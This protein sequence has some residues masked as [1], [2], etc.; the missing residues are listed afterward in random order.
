MAERLRVQRVGRREFSGATL[1]RLRRAVQRCAFVAVDTELGGL[2]CLDQ[3]VSCSDVVSSLRVHVSLSRSRCVHVRVALLSNAVRVVFGVTKGL[4]AAAFAVDRM[5][6][7]VMDAVETRYA[8]LRASAQQFPIVEFGLSVFTWDQRARAFRVETFAFPIFPV[9]HEPTDQHAQAQYTSEA[10]ASAAAPAAPAPA[11]LQQLPDRRFLLQAKC[12][13]YIRAHGFDLNRW[14]DEGIGYLSHREQRELGREL[15]SVPPGSVKY[16]HMDTRPGRGPGA[17]SLVSNEL[18]A[19]MDAVTRKIADSVAAFP[20]ATDQTDQRSRR[21][22]LRRPAAPSEENGTGQAAAG[23][24]EV[25]GDESR[26]DDSERLDE[27]EDG[28]HVGEGDYRAGMREIRIMKRFLQNPIRPTTTSSPLSNMPCPTIVTEPLAPFRRHAVLHH[29]QTQFP[30]AF[31]FDCPADNDESGDQ[32]ASPRANASAAAAANA[33]GNATPWRRCVRVLVPTSPTQQVAL[34]LASSQLTDSARRERNAKLVGFTAVLDLI[35]TS[36]KPIVGHNMLLD[37]LQCF[38]KFH[39][40][41]PARCAAFQAQLFDWICNGKGVD[42]DNSAP[43]TTNSNAHGGIGGL[44]DT[45]EMVAAAMQSIDA[46]AA[47]VQPHSALEHCFTVFSGAPFVGPRVIIDSDDAPA[48]GRSRHHYNHHSRQQHRDDSHEHSQSPP[49]PPP[50]SPPLNPSSPRLMAHQAGYDAFM[51]GFVFLRVCAAL[52]VPNAAVAALGD[53][54]AFAKL[55]PGSRSTLESF[56]NAFHLSHLLPA[57]RLTLPG[58]FPRNVKTPSRSHFLRVRLTRTYAPSPR[59]SVPGSSLKSFHIKQ[60]LSWAL[61][62]PANRLAVH[63]EGSKCVYVALPSRED[64]EA[65]LKMREE[66]QEA[67][68]SAKD[69]MPSIGCVDFERCGGST[70]SEDDDAREEDAEMENFD[71]DKR[72]WRRDDESSDEDEW[73]AR[74]RKTGDF[75]GPGSGWT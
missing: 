52:G 47:L 8:Q 27:S 28:E 54:A 2:S 67:Q 64:A 14:V 37:M 5:R 34:M 49:P 7:S 75:P 29:V 3:C 6:P 53:A 10:A 42:D 11:P 68:G 57:T 18:Q 1:R 69:P 36:R 62:V 59:S 4:T 65:L 48:N 33:N 20:A 38:D 72:H 70:S 71:W 17:P 56:R 60:C 24:S 25:E 61:D 35:V 15:S 51:T 40:P 45:K 32:G 21:G 43:N 23:H 50:L 26:R 74:K 19:V 16:I 12:L 73:V 9:A 55:S 22:H 44:F 41:L 39:A 58:P 30:T 66:T 13:Q 46:C 63:W 31:M